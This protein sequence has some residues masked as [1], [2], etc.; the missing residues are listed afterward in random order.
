[1]EKVC[2]SWLTQNLK[3]N[4]MKVFVTFIVG[5][6]GTFFI[7]SCNSNSETA[8]KIADVEKKYQDSLSVLRNELKEAKSQIELLS[9]PADQRLHKAK[10]LLSAGELDKAATEIEQLKRLFPNSSETSASSELL[11]Q[12]SE[13]KEA[14]RKEEER[15]K[16]LGFKALNIVQNVTIGENKITFSNMKIGLKYTHDVYPTYSGSEWRE[17]TA[18]KGS[19]F[20]SY[21]MDIT[22]SSKDPDIPTIAFY[23]VDGERLIHQKTFW[24]NFARWSDY[25]CYLGNEPD[26]K[27]DFAKVSTVKFRVGAQLEDRYF[28][29]PYVIVLRTVN[30]LS[31]NYDRFENPPVSY[32][33]DA[34][35]PVSLTIDNFKNGQFVALKVANL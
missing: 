7:C 12:I 14:K 8:S 31:R 17:H 32:S 23:S 3:Q 27:N 5:L 33:G 2:A 29:N 11:T 18:D 20:I 24:V 9:Y 35:Y 34:G 10:E 21:N 16:A 30:T 1:M 13:L 19:S 26:H 15:I 4:N 25:G 28:K 22:S 6:L